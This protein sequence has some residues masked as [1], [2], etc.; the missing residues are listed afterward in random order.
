MDP[1]PRVVKRKWVKIWKIRNLMKDKTFGAGR[2]KG[3]PEFK[4]SIIFLHTTTNL[5]TERTQRQK[6]KGRQ[7]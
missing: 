5:Q 3:G 1:P 2:L 4:Y 7:T 6:N